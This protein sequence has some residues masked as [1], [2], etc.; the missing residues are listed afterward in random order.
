MS[1]DEKLLIGQ[2][3]VVYMIELVLQKWPMKQARYGCMKTKVIRNDI[4]DSS[5][6]H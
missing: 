4:I 6:A 2:L 1:D 3:V 5:A